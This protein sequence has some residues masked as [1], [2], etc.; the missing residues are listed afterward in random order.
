MIVFNPSTEIL[1]FIRSSMS[2]ILTSLPWTKKTSLWVDSL[3]IE[4]ESQDDAR[5]LNRR[6]GSRSR[7][8]SKRRENGYREA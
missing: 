3:I 7:T 8:N 2:D 5:Q 4:I 6:K 1:N